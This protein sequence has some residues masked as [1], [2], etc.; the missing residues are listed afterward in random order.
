LFFVVAVVVVVI[1][2]VVFLVVVLVLVHTGNLDLISKNAW[3]PVF[4]GMI[5]VQCFGQHFVVEACDE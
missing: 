2:V 1:I 3:L 4:S 5:C